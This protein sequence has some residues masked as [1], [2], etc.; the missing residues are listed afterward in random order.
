MADKLKNP[1]DNEQAPEHPDV[2]VAHQEIINQT[3]QAKDNAKTRA[4]RDVP[5]RHQEPEDKAQ[6]DPEPFVDFDQ[7]H[8]SQERWDRDG[9]DGDT[10]I[11]K[12][13]VGAMLVKR[14]VFNKVLMQS[15]SSRH[16]GHTYYL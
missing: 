5:D 3:D 12:E 14:S 4:Q 1:A 9:E 11:V 7:F 15:S 13:F 10:E 2:Q 6:V 8:L 16:G